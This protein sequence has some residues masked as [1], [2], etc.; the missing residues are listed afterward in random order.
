MALT[1]GQFNEMVDQHGAVIYRTAY[2]LVGNAHEA[3]DMVQETFRSAWRSRERFE[4]G[5][6]TRAWLIAILRR[7]VADFWRRSRPSVV[8]TTGAEINAEYQAEDPFRDEFTDEM[9]KGLDSLPDSMREALLLVI[10]AELTHQE[11]ADLLGVPLGTVLSR[12][13]R[14]RNRLREYFNQLAAEST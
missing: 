4:E 2:R 6:G 10:V 14:A 3:E 8:S 7:R 9:Q 5:R 12:V 13:S 1:L 11:V